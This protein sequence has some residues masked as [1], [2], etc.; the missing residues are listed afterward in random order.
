MPHL[1]RRIV[2]LAGL[3]P[4]LALAVPAI[5]QAD[6]LAITHDSD[7]VENA[8]FRVN[9]NYS[10]TASGESIYATIK[11]S[12]GA[13]CGVDYSA[14][15]G[16]D[17]DYND[18]ISGSGTT[19]AQITEP[20]GTY[21]VCAYEQ[22]SS[23]QTSP[24]AVAQTT[25]SVRQIHASLSLVLPARA[26]LNVPFGLKATYTVE[27]PRNLWVSYAKVAPGAQCPQ[28]YS[29]EPSGFTD[30]IYNDSLA[31]QGI[32][33][34]NVTLDGNG[35]YLF[36]GWVQQT[37]GDTDPAAVAEATVTVGPVAQ[38]HPHP[39]V[40][41]RQSLAVRAADRALNRARAIERRRPSAPHRR[42]V[43]AASRRAKR[44]TLALRRCRAA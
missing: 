13:G 24:D 32:D 29:L 10:T 9:F 14:D 1:F 5:A 44:A 18:S 6:T 35:T 25:I 40:C 30:A 34:A 33:A 11:A 21:L 26:A 16:S 31:G 4:V 38:P 37:S 23:G 39:P 28:T 22:Q 43:G 20:Q 15:G 41:R 27:Q 17:I 12:G 42:A 7:P 19:T 36:C 2:L 3:T 8:P